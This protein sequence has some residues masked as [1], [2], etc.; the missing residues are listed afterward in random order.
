MK[1]VL[2]KLLREVKSEEEKIKRELAVGK[3]DKERVAYLMGYMD[4]VE[5]VKGKI[6]DILNICYACEEVQGDE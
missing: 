3:L 2:Q 4:A 6:F 1:V 5:K